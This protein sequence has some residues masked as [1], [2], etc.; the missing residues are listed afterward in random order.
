VHETGWK[1]NGAVILAIS[2]L[3]IL[4]RSQSDSVLIIR[5]L[6]VFYIHIFDG[7]ESSMAGSQ[8]PQLLGSGSG[9]WYDS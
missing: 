2:R 9:S 6:L 1:V 5:V 4:D 7:F 3:A 8:Y